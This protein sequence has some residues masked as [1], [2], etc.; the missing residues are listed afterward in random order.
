MNKYEA[1]ALQ[2]AR[3]FASE[4]EKILKLS[5]VETVLVQ[6]TEGHTRFSAAASRGFDVVDDA[7]VAAMLINLFMWIGQIRRGQVF[8]N[9]SKCEIIRELIIRVLD[10]DQL[11]ED[12]KKRLVVGAWSKC[13]DAVN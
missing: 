6:V 10:N 1:E 3:S 13:S 9:D 2:N 8:R 4:A 11:S 12:E 7:S 5:G